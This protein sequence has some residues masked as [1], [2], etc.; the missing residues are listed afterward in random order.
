MKAPVPFH[1]VAGLLF[2]AVLSR[3]EVLPFTDRS[4][5]S[6]A[7]PAATNVINFENHSGSEGYLPEFT[8]LG[9]VTFH[10][11]TNYGQEVIDGYNIGQAGNKVY[12]TI[13][14]DLTQ[15]IADITFG[16]G[17]LA[18]GF[19]LKNTG[20]NATTGSQGFLATLYS[21][22]TMLGTF[23]ISSPPGGTTFQFAGYVSSAPITRITF[24][25]YEASPNQ[26]IVLDNF[27][28]SSELELRLTS[29]QALNSDVRLSFNTI[30]GTTNF[31]QAATVLTNEASS[32]SDIS[33]GIVATGSGQVS[34]NY[35]DSGA[36]TNFP[37]R[38]YRIRLA[39]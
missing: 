22:A 21:Y 31:V 6:S 39:L 23:P 24:S 11:S 19:D 32:F 15:T 30:G 3:A 7:A 17:V 10:T 18:V 5:F 12:V 8:E 4:T 26:N 35:V 13:A 33:A 34:A 9:F 29:I 1:L 37:V 14:A 38:F 16:Y 28:L 2:V 20:N 27:A 36:V 25:S